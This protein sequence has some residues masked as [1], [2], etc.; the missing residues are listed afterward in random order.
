MMTVSITVY[1]SNL[2]WS[3]CSTL[4]RV[5]GLRDTL[6]VVGSS[7]PDKMRSRVLLPAPLAPMMP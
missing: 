6:P 4:M 5:P 7:S 2:K 3:C 1:P